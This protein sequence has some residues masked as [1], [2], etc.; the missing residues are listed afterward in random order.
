M[1]KTFLASLM[2][3]VLSLAAVAQQR[4]TSGLHENAK[5]FIR[6]GD[7]VNALVVLNH[8]LQQDPQNLEVLKD[9]AFTYYLQK[10][11]PK[12]LA[13]AKPLPDRPDADVQ[14][15]QVLAL[16]YKAMEDRK[17][18]EKLYRQGL[19]KF[20][21]SGALYNEYGEVLGTKD[22]VEAIKQWEKG[23]E[24]DPNYSGNYYNA[25]KYYYVKNE[26]AWSLLYGEIFVNLE[27]YSRRTTEM[28]DLVTDAY[29]QLFANMDVQLKL[30]AKNAFLLA[31]LTTLNN[32]S[33]AIAQGIS[34]D[35]LSALRSA[36]ITD[37]SEKNAVAFPFRLFDYHRQLVKEGM[38]DAYNQWLFGDAQDPQG[39][40]KWT[41]AHAPEYN[42]FI[43]YQKGRIFK[44][45]AGQH[46]QTVSSK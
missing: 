29:K 13:T 36:F 39:F 35:A 40:E 3:S 8:A 26:K 6:Q 11:Y 30:A 24:T 44:M 22:G 33:A 5:A 12:A 43:E 31:F 42:R 25:S 7:Y 21:Q 14:S 34:A 9:L 27:S 28:K 1:K 38:F 10:D 37:W 45:P 18:C 19:K 46:Y 23:I 41:K 4:D 32:H 17:E 20:P 2:F 15:Y 16:I